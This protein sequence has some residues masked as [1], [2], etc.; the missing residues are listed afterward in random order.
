MHTH[1]YT[2]SGGG[3]EGKGKDKEI[4]RLRVF[5]WST[6]PVPLEAAKSGL[7]AK[8]DTFSCNVYLDFIFIYI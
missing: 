4:Y 2:Y 1:I 6:A 8:H 3:N 7:T 5:I